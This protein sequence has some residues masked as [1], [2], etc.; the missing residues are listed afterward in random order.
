M[1]TVHA[2]VLSAGGL[3]LAAHVQAQSPAGAAPSPLRD[4]QLEWTRSARPPLEGAAAGAV[5][6]AALNRL[7]PAV[8][9]A[10]VDAPQIWTL[11]LQD[12]TL[13][14]VLSRWAAQAKYQ[15]LWQV[16]RDFPIESEMVFEG[17]FK[18]VVGDVMVGVS[19][20]DFPLQAIFNTPGRVVRV[21]R[22]LEEKEPRR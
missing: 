2:C 13:Y 16:D 18:T 22:Y 7:L 1:K 5:P 11:A 15:L 14:R 20:T 12:K 9:P 6:S 21:V 3:L 4:A 17:D 8:V 19:E 10:A